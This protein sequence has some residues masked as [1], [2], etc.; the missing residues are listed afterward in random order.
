MQVDTL[1]LERKEAQTAVAES[2]NNA[3]AQEAQRNAYAQLMPLAL[4]APPTAGQSYGQSPT[5]YGAPP[6]GYSQ[7]P[8]AV[9]PTGYGAPQPYM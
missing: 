2:E 6:T 3:A 1:M 8:Y 5:G 7:A 4:P 9:P